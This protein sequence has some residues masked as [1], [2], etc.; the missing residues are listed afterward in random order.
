MELLAGERQSS[1][2]DRAV[3]A[4]ND[5]LRLGAGRT[6][7]K[8]LERYRR[9]RKKSE[10]ATDSYDTLQ[11]WSS[12]YDWQDRASIYDTGVEQQKN[13]R[14]QKEMDA[15]LAL[16][17]E[18]V[19]RLKRLAKFIEDQ[20]YEEAPPAAT[21]QIDDK[22]ITVAPVSPYPK[23]W[24]ADVKQVGVEKVDII[25]FNQAII[26]EFRGL[27]DDLAKET[28]G[29]KAKTELSGTV[30]TVQMPFSEWEKRT[31]SVMV[32]VSKTMN[33]FEDE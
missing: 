18:R 10:P 16:D 24:L 1:E 27:L 11:K 23:L 26:S 6:L 32:K 20:I 29:R 33:D 4:C 2:T 9:S 13:E 7:P 30:G 28:G 5:F 14:R 22:E 17:Y 8:L 3:Q 31:E 25:R 15:G 19:R 21:F 12:Q